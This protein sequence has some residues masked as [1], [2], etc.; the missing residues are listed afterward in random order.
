[1]SPSASLAAIMALK[2]MPSE[3]VNGPFVVIA[4][5]SL[6]GKTVSVTWLLVAVRLASLAVKLMALAPLK[7]A[8]GV[9]VTMPL[10]E[11]AAVMLAM[12]DEV[13][14]SAS[15]SGSLK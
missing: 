11:I 10:P 1:M 14:V 6:T 12:V 8:A 2:G 13:N 7:F 5:A 4:G 3:M 9:R 15:P